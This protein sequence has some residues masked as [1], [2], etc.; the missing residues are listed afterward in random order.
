MALLNNRYYQD[1]LSVVANL[2]FIHWEKIENKSLLITGATGLICSFLID[3][4]MF[5]NKYFESN[6][7]VYSLSRNSVSAKKRFSAYWTDPLFNYI[8]QDIVDEIKLDEKVDYIIHGASNAHPASYAADP[9]GTIKSNVWGIN[10]LL[11]YSLKAQCKRV[12][13]ISSGEVYGEGNGEDF[14]ESYSGYINPLNARSCY[15]SSKRTSENLCISYLDQYNVDVVIARPCH[16][17]GPTMTESD[18]RAFAQFLRNVLAGN[19]VV[20]K[21]KGAQCRSYCYVA[22]CISALLVILLNGKVG[23]AYNIANKKSNITVGELAEAI[24][25]ARQRKV[26]YDIPSNE[27]QKGYSVITRAVLS[28]GKLDSLGWYPKYTLTDSIQKVIE[29]LLDK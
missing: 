9:V 2:D 8:Q 4:L 18:N 13:Y 21:S 19:D 23:E 17:Y 11:D 28:S 24:A 1:D 25:T 6:I 27:E 15:P 20:L 10:N 22:D 26:I 29:I 12:L 16:V 14:I 7:M 5:R 3:V